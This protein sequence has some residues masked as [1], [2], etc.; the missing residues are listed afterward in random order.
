MHQKVRKGIPSPKDRTLYNNYLT[1]VSD[2]T[3]ICSIQCQNDNDIVQIL[4]K[5]FD[6]ISIFPK[7]PE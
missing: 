1:L 7:N 4:M 2:I 5:G 6:I 3:E